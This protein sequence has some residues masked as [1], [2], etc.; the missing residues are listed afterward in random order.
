MIKFVTIPKP[1]WWTKFTGA[2]LYQEDKITFKN[3]SRNIGK[4]QEKL[5]TMSF[6]AGYLY[7]YYRHVLK[8]F[9][10]KE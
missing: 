3:F 10:T 1:I 4:G 5:G 7:W 9:K 2:L 8:V 6:F